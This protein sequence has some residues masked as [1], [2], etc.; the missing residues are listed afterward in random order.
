MIILYIVGNISKLFHITQGSIP[1]MGLIKTPA[2]LADITLAIILYRYA[3]QNKAGAAIF[4]ALWF[5]L[6]FGIAINSVFWGQIDSVWVMMIVISI[7]LLTKDKKIPAVIMFILAILT[8]TQSFVFAPIYLAYFITE[9]RP[10]V[11]LL[12]I[13]SAL[14]LVY[15]VAIPFTLNFDFTWLYDKYRYAMNLYKYRTMNAFNLYFL[16]G[17]NYKSSEGMMFSAI[18][19]IVAASFSLY[20]MFTILFK[21]NAN[22][23]FYTAYLLMFGIFVLMPQMHERYIF[24]ALVFLYFAFVSFSAEL[25][26]KLLP[27]MITISI[28]TYANCHY[29][30]IYNEGATPNNFLTFGLSL[31]NVIALGYSILFSISL[32]K[33]NTKEKANV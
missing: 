24:P 16:L 14:A 2:M 18:S 10:K 13:A 29:A 33:Y 30:L 5:L 6:D 19:I 31:V 28:T 32:F 27:L 17:W 21:K 25:R 12:S 26:K 11:W 23:I 20:S 1:Y 9:K 4:A 7:L 15:I 3:K 22:N 8:K